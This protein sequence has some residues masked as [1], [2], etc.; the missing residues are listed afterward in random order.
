MPSNFPSRLFLHVQLASVFSYLSMLRVQPDN[1]PPNLPS[2]TPTI[3]FSVKLAH[4]TLKKLESDPAS[5]PM[6]LKLEHIAQDAESGN[7]GVRLTLHS[8]TAIMGTPRDP[9]RRFEYP[10]PS[11]DL[12]GY[13]PFDVPSHPNTL[14]ASMPRAL[15]KPSLLHPEH[16]P[17]EPPVPPSL[18]KK[19]LQFDLHL[20]LRRSTLHDV[21]IE[22]RSKSPASG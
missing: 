5:S 21:I 18:A 1:D 15:N 19:A 11:P 9:S 6:T 2:S 12:Q 16:T 22:T 10:F 14:L 7:S 8:P 13:V 4:I 3:D 20:P 17:R